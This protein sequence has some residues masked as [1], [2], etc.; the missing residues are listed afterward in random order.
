MR[1]KKKDRK[2]IQVLVDG[3]MIDWSLTNTELKARHNICPTLLAL[4]RKNTSNGIIRRGTYKTR[5]LDFSKVDWSNNNCRI[6]RDLG[7]YPAIVSK[8]RISHGFPSA[9][10]A[11]RK[12]AHRITPEMAGSIDW[13]RSSNAALASKF[14]CSRQ[15][16]FQFRIANKL[17]VMDY[18]Y[19]GTGLVIFKDSATQ[20]RETELQLAR[21]VHK[22]IAVAAV[23][24]I[25][26]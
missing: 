7:T 5:N 1:Y 24:G 10:L 3:V 14:S 12:N 8:Y 26:P 19:R 20:I 4:L 11:T 18:K 22:S 15:C 25:H 23:S 9:S 13:V 2:Q 16:I 17:P 21:D 6:A